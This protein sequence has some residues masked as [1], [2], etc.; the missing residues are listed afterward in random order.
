MAKN[1]Q[2]EQI[3]E[4]GKRRR[5]R[6]VLKRVLIGASL[7]VAFLAVYALVLPASTLEH[8]EPACGLEEHEHT[9]A[10]FETQLVC[11]LPETGAH[12]HTQACYDAE[13]VTKLVC[14]KPATGHLHTQKCF[15]TGEELVCENTE[16]DHE[17]GDECY[18]E[19]G[20]LVCEE[21]ET[22]HV[23]TDACYE[24]VEPEDADAQE[25]VEGDNAQAAEEA[26]VAEVQA[27]AE[28]TEAQPE[29]DPALDADVEASDPADQK[30]EY[31]LICDKEADGH[32]H[33]SQCYDTEG[34]LTCTEEEAV[35]VAHEHEDACSEEVAVCGL[36][37]HNHDE[38]CYDPETLQMIQATKEN[39]E[40]QEAEEAAKAEEAETTPEPVSDDELEA[41]KAK[42]L[43]WENENMVVTFT[44]PEDTKEEV[45]FEVTEQPVAE[46]DLSE[47]VKADENAWQNNL[48]IEA[49]KAG[50]VVE[51]IV[52]LNA[53]TRIQV[54]PEAV[55]P[56]LDGIDF[57][58]VL[59]EA[60]EATG[61]VVVIESSFAAKEDEE[62]SSDEVLRET[63]Q[64]TSESSPMATSF[65][66]LSEGV[67]VSAFRSVNPQ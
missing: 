34:N 18:L 62:A 7:C 3:E 32:V 49:T 50:E 1:L 55:E 66:L 42:G 26:E 41:L 14:E 33:F 23:H 67:S 21:E 40:A 6:R 16:A 56:I 57:S 58:E 60:K 47:E 22:V 19:E 24:L 54:K 4:Y 10:C 27:D 12:V 44:L 43:A 51:D 2:N 65:A 31:R 39:K 30:P 5:Q 59:D 53:S 8:P 38:V 36:E 61:A 64:S 11:Q 20:T 63:Y 45:R 17:H 15:A 9:E 29:S 28:S 35:E 46:S 25:A 48:H 52:E 37:A 13:D